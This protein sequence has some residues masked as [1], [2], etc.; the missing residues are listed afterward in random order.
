MKLNQSL[1]LEKL[2]YIQNI[3]NDFKLLLHYKIQLLLI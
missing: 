1:P 2:Q 3:P